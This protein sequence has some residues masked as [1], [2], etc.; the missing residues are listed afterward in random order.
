M[1]SEVC[2]D[3]AECRALAAEMRANAEALSAMRDEPLPFPVIEKRGRAIAW[4]LA[5]AAALLFSLL[6]PVAMQHDTPAPSHNPSNRE[7]LKVKMVTADPDVVI[8]WLIDAPE[9]VSR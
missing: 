9:G 4:P 6:A 5:A 3:C 2:G 7:P 8:F 1:K